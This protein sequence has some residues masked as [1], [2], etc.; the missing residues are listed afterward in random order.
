[1]GIKALSSASVF[2]NCCRHGRGREM[3]KLHFLNFSL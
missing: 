2:S 1:L 3:V